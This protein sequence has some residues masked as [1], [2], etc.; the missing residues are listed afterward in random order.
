MLL[1]PTFNYYVYL[2]IR[3]DYVF[4]CDNHGGM[5]PEKIVMKTKVYDIFKEL[6]EKDDILS[7]WDIPVVKDDTI[8]TAWKFVGAPVLE[9]KKCML[10]GI[11]VGK[12]VR[13]HNL[14]ESWVCEHCYDRITRNM[15]MM[16]NKWQKIVRDN[17]KRVAQNMDKEYFENY[18]NLLFGDAIDDF[19]LR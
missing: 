4:Y 9:H 17:N 18:K 3:K 10:C 7:F 5:K 14:D 1:D 2:S 16:D 11:V 13:G 8:N 6:F 12:K 15:G 19:E